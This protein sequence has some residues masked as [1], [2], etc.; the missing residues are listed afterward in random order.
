M[1]DENIRQ[2][3]EALR[4]RNLYF[5]NVNG[6]ENAEFATAFKRYQSRKGFP[7]TGTWMTN[8][9]SVPSYSNPR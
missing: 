8:T 6:R 3:Q 1:A 5:G 4:K 9:A 2:A 7:A